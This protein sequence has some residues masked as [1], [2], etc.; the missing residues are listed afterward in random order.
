MRLSLDKMIL[1]AALTFAIVVLP[2]TS[3]CQ[4]DAGTVPA[5]TPLALVIDQHYKMRTGEPIRAHL[6]HP[7]YADNKL[8]LPADTTV[9]GSVVALDSDHTR[10]VQAILGG[11]FTPFHT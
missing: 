10:R 2:G 8:L 3:Y 6:L 11:D 9:A 4:T 1:R 7:I 5:G